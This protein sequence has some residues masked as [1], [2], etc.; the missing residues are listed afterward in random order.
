M[1][2]DRAVEY[3][4]QGNQFF[5]TQS[6]ED[7]LTRYAKG[8]AYLSDVVP[9]TLVESAYDAKEKKLFQLC[10]ATLTSCTTNI[11][12]TLLK[13][14]RNTEVIDEMNSALAYT[15]DSIKALYHIA[16]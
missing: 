5:K 1:G 4:N 12:M 9:V 10:V 16:L 14:N 15:P 2:A 13:L 8:R 3:K 7:A 6:Y 11:G